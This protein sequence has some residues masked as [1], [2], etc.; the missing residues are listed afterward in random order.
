[1]SRKV[2]TLAGA[3]LIALSTA[4]PTPSLAHEAGEFLIRVRGIVV[5]PDESGS[6]SAIGGDIQVSTSIVPEIDFSYFFTD[7][8]SLELIAAVSKHSLEAKGTAAGNVDLG[9]T[10]VLPPTLLAQYHFF[11]DSMVSPYIGIGLNY[12]IFFDESAG[13][14]ASSVSI[15]DA[16]G[17]AFQAGFDLQFPDSNFVF[18]ADAKY[19]L[20]SPDVKARVGG[21]RIKSNNFDLNPWIFGFGFGYKL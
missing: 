19:I 20:L 16:I 10:W 6:L 5:M 14:V 17:P 13:P 11:S 21:T 1:M 12:T 18:N 4:L 2:A 9:N 3:T 15:D 7:A 8:F